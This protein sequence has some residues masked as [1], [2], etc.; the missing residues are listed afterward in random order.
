MVVSGA[1]TLY[2]TYAT[3][4]TWKGWKA[5]SGAVWSLKSNKLRPDGWTSA[6]AAGLPI[7][8]GLL[9]WSEVRADR[10]TT[11][12]GSPPTR[13]A[14]PPV[15]GSARRRIDAVGGVPAD[16]SAVPAQGRVAPR[17]MSV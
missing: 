14:L 9:R 17:G 2:E 10:S 4:K 13:P 6:D 12:S 16:G 7:L 11:R 5:G 15:A 1:C 8:P 3:S